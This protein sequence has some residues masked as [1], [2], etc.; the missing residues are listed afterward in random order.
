MGEKLLVIQVAGLGH[1]LLTKQAGG[2]AWAG[3]HWQPAESVFPALTCPVQA[4]FRTAAPPSEHGM[5]FNGTWSRA[6]RRPQ[7]WEQSA[8]YVQGPRIWDGFRA[9]GGRVGLLFWQQSLG[10]A[11][12]DLLSPAPIHKHHGGMIEDVYSRPPGLYAELCRRVGRRFK[13]RSYWGPLASAASSRWIAAATAELMRLPDISPDL[14]LTYLPHLDYALLRH[15][16]SSPQAARAFAEL[17]G[18]LEPLLQAAEASGYEVLVFGD[19]AFADVTRP[20]FPNRLLREMGLLDVRDIGG[21]LYPD[22]TY[23]RAFAVVDHE[24]AHVY[25]PQGPDRPEQTDPSDLSDLVEAFRGMD[26]VGEVLTYEGL[27]A[28]GLAHPNTG[29]LVLV[30]ADGAWFAYPWWHE[31]R[32]Q[33]DYASHVDIHQKPGFDPCELFFGWPPPG[34]STNPARVRGSHGRVG[35]ARRVAWA[36]TGGL[37]PEGDSLL[38]LAKAVQRRLGV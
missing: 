30:A 28:A 33:P 11:A 12:S 18:L 3:L 14:L 1:D 13:L 7:F 10:E 23:S 22:F 31:R 25:L 19:Y 37:E 36:A 29:D 17:G 32:E 4:S 16:P 20:V 27:A 38:G 6:L 34:V 21:R 24:I 8:A 5:V 2:T 35:P 9:A 26:G 15:G